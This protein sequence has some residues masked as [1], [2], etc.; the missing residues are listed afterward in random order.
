MGQRVVD[1]VWEVVVI[2][3][4]GEIEVLAEVV[5]ALVVDERGQNAF[6]RQRRGGQARPPA[7]VVRAD[8]KPRDFLVAGGLRGG[9]RVGIELLSVECIDVE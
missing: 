2:V 3:D 9:R 7:F 4:A 8:E 1:Q 6:G 5:R